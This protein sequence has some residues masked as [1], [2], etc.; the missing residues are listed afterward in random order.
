MK[1]GVVTLGDDL[2]TLRKRPLPKRCSLMQMRAYAKEGRLLVLAHGQWRVVALVVWIWMTPKGRR[3]TLYYDT[4]G[5]WVGRRMRKSPIP[6][7]AL[8][9][10]DD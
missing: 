9:V 1:K 10:D 3:V 5:T 6:L 2:K 4:D 7:L 8:R